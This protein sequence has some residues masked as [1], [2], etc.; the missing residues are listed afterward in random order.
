MSGGR[1]T[2]ITLQEFVDDHY[3][4]KIG[5][6]ECVVLLGNDMLES[7]FPVSRVEFVTQTA[8]SSW[9]DVYNRHFERIRCENDTV[10]RV[11]WFAQTE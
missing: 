6:G 7:Y 1:W 10:F 8:I 5:R 9:Y 2:Y 3:E 4:A 11:I